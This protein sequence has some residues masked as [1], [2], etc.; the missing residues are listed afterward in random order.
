MLRSRKAL[1]AQSWILRHSALFASGGSDLARRT[2]S[3]SPLHF[4]FWV[5]GFEKSAQLIC[6]SCTV[7][8][9]VLHLVRH[10]GKRELAFVRLKDRI[11]AKTVPATRRIDNFPLHDS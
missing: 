6:C 3:A 8:D 7:A 9:A 2:K 1:A 11:I 10:F 5:F 4:R